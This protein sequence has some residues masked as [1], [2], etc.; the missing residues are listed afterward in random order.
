MVQITADDLPWRPIDE[1]TPKGQFL[2]LRG[3]SGCAGTPHRYVAAKHDADFRPR[4]PWVDASGDS[5]LDDG[6]MPIEWVRL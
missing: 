6:E 1:N 3:P 2:L 5:V 4:Q